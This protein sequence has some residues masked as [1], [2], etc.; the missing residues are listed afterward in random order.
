MSSD[1]PPPI[2]LNDPI[3]I[4]SQRLF[5]FPPHE[6]QSD[7][8]RSLLQAHRQTTVTN[9]LVIRPTGGGKSLIYQV[10]ATMIKGI[11][12]FISPLLAL[13][14]EQTRKNAFSARLF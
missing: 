9:M 11:T 5:Q 6:W 12:L 2:E 7:V 14:S 8:I 4:A 1:P 13:A 3:S 10:A